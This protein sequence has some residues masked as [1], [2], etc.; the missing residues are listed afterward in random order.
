MLRPTE[1]RKR[2]EEEGRERGRKREGGKEGEGGQWREREGGRKSGNITKVPL[3]VRA[4]PCKV[5]ISGKIVLKRQ[6]PGSP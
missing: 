6:I 4:R 5:N 2:K 3:G 1:R